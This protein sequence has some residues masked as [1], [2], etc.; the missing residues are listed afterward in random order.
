MLVLG[1]GAL[2]FAFAAEAH[3]W[4]LAADPSLD[5]SAMV[6]LVH[7]ESASTAVSL[8]KAGFPLVGIGTI[9][10]MAGL[11]RS[12]AVPRWQ[13]ALVLV[14]TVASLA[15]APGSPIAPL[16]ITPAVVGYLALAG[17]VLRSPAPQAADRSPEPAATS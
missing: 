17:R 4:S 14:G 5:R 1:S 13:P 8:L 11:L 3:L 15:A 12:A 10:L 7:L 16:L 2:T 6:A 9:L